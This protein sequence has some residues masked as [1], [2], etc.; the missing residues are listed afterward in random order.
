[1]VAWNL[2]AGQASSGLHEH[3]PEP[4]VP[5]SNRRIELVHP[6]LFEA[7]PIESKSTEVSGVGV[8]VPILEIW[9]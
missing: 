6:P 7:R 5:S 4:E 2:I 3:T 8:T 1:M 9:A